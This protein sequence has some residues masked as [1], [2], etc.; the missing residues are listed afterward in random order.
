MAREKCEVCGRAAATFVTD[1]AETEPVHADG[2]TWMNW[3]RVGERHHY[4]KSHAR[5]RIEYVN[6]PI[7]H[8]FAREVM[9][10]GVDRNE[11]LW[12]DCEVRP[13]SEAPA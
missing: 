6:N 1:L 8:A 13:L 11:I 3:R 4:C 9:L 5:L 2:V 12:K 10:R 7:I